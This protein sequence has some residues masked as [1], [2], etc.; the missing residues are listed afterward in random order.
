MA[1]DLTAVRS[2]GALLPSDL[3]DSHDP[4]ASPELNE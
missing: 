4:G 1:G 2:V 3:L